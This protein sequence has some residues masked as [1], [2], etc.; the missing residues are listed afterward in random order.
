MT[1]WI[2]AGGVS[3]TSHSP[4]KLSTS[5][6]FWALGADCSQI[7]NDSKWAGAASAGNSQY[8]W[9][10]GSNPAHPTKGGA[11][12]GGSEVFADGSA[13]WCKFNTMYRFNEWNNNMG[14]LDSYWYQ[15]TSDFET[16]LA[17]RL[18][19]IK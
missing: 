17:K 3:Y 5:K 9:E 4:V 1:N 12:A 18:P 13:Q 6:P 2:I 8:N 16:A 11:P 7:V 10:Y 14:I 19:D 15:D